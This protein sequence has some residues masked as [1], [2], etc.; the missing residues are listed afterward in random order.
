MLV[1]LN[2]ITGGVNMFTC[3]TLSDLHQTM[4]RIGV[5]LPLSSE[6]GALRRPL[7][8]AGRTLLNRIAIQPMEGCDSAP[9][10]AP[11]ELTIRRYDRFAR[12]GAALIWFEACAVRRE[13]RA[14]PRQ[15][16][17]TSDNLDDFRR[18]TERI[19]ETAVQS[20]HEPPLLIL[21]ATHSGRYSKPDG[22]PAPVIACNNPLFEKDAPLSASCIISDDAL[23]RLE[24]DFA[25]TARLAQAA[26]F[27]GVDIKCCHRYLTSELLSAFTRPGAFGGSFE[28][29]TRLLRES[30]G[31]AKAVVTGD[32]LITSRLNVYDGFPYPYGF[33]VQDDGSLAPDLTE[34]IRLVGELQKLGLELLDV[35]IGNPYVN[36]HVNRPADWQ[37][38][39][40]PEEPLQGLAR[41]M[42]CVGGI[43]RA[44]PSLSVIGS[45]FSYPRAFAGNLAAGAIE[46]GVC[47]LA[48]FGRMAFAY[49]DFA[50]DLLSGRGLDAR[51]CCVACGKCSQLMRLGGTAGC[52]VRDP[53]YTR[54]YKELTS[55]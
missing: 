27:D 21:Q 26:G 23:F 55:K 11:G 20:G 44:F 34:P 35:T 36:P 14:N 37:P 25:Q 15:S 31:K 48:G 39:P 5:C 38:Y 19:R 29:R 41:M 3:K 51:K 45:A 46:A 17:L 12:S 33:G 6:Y 1:L 9:D 30:Y 54:L 7:T 32:F 8:V 42:D 2:A 28:N 47:D 52:A 22:V 10:G 43:K 24:D 13:G 49:P 40:L 50:D 4:E 18:L 53:Y 16:F